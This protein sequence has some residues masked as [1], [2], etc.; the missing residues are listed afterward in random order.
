MPVAV[1]PLAGGHLPGRLVVVGALLIAAATVLGA[2]LA[3]VPGGMRP[4]WARPAARCW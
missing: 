1:V 4:G 3:V 2:W